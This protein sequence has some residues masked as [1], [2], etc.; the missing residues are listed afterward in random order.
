MFIENN[1]FWVCEH[2]FKSKVEGIAKLMLENFINY[3]MI[4]D[5]KDCD[6][7]RRSEAAKEGWKTRRYE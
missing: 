2:G 3:T 7:E 1:Q 4:C 6:H 5:C